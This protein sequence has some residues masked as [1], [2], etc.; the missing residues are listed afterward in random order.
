MSSP[1]RTWTQSSSLSFRKQNRA[2]NTITM[3]YSIGNKNSKPL[4]P[5]LDLHCEK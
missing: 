4:C 3:Y 1:Q 5:P 2:I